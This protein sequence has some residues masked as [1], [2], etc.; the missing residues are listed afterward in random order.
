MAVIT[1][2]GYFGTPPLVR[3]GLIV[4]YDSANIR[5]Y[6]SGSTTFT[7]LSGRGIN[8]TIGAGTTFDSVNG[9]V[10]IT[11]ASSC[12]LPSNTFT[13]GSPQQGTFSIKLKLP[14]LSTSA[15]TTLFYDGGGISNN[16]Q[17]YR[18]AANPTGQYQWVIYYNAGNVLVTSTYLPEVWYDVALTFDSS[19]NYGVYKN[20]QVIG[21]GTASGFTSWS[22]TGTLPPNFRSDSNVGTGSVAQFFAYNRALTQTEI[23]QNYNATKARFNIT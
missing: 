8:A 9:G 17:F 1:K 10:L 12:T 3:D 19:G 18:N 21:R 20:G 22:R 14:P 7:D 15:A 16:I 13:S 23:L 5:S 2:N 11:S 6:T 4:H